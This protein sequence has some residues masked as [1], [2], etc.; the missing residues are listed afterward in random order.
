MEDW[1]YGW[2]RGRTYAL[3]LHPSILPLFHSSTPPFVPG[4]V[5]N[6][7]CLGKL[8]REYP[9]VPGQTHRLARS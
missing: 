4:K 9:Q 1:K 8:P 3:L 6:P 2:R 5:E 7:V